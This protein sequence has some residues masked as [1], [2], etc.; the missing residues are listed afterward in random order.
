MAQGTP[1]EQGRVREPIGPT[2]RGAH[3][4]PASGLRFGRIAG[5][6][7]YVDWSVTII[8]ALVAFGLGAGAL[9]QWHPDWS[10]VVR[11]VVALGAALAFFVSILLHELS[12]ALVGR[13]Q[14]IPIP[15]I[16]LFVF[17][18]MAHLQGEPSTPKAEL[19]MAAVGPLTS[20]VIGVA[21]SLV[22]VQLAS[23]GSGAAAGSPEELLR[24]AGPVATI[25][26]WLGPINVILAVFNLVPGFPLD[27][28]RVLRA[29]LWSATGD[30]DKATRWASGAGRAV[31]WTLIAMGLLM[32]F[33]FW[34]PFFGTGLASGLWIA[35]IGWFLNN[36]ARASYVALRVKTRLAHVSVREVM[37]SSL[38]TV[39][40]DTPI[41]ELV[42]EHIMKSDQ[43]SFPV[44]E[45]TELAGV[46]S[47]RDVQL[48]PSEDWPVVR[49][50]QVMI[51]ATEVP[52]IES[53]ADASV[54]L[55]V[56]AARDVEQLP[57]VD[58][59]RLSGFV[60]RQDILKWLSLQPDF[61]T[62]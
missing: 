61:A 41:A 25:L 49:V 11:W 47:I 6:D 30:L 13:A 45:G 20:L 19:L 43:T 34:I 51:P 60:R 27:G 24:A 22:G 28:G 33:G 37:R 31:G 57:V 29:A 36:A 39:T 26:L 35:L 8:F 12:H 1:S 44:V 3:V 38:D 55:E 62:S 48:V 10:P 14:G 32:A 42:R 58:H 17:G 40:P 18:G 4:H 7:L 53:D 9:P 15:R 50:R 59:G 23:L 56:L 21:S 52:A 5:I 54:A 16:T 46:I 2:A